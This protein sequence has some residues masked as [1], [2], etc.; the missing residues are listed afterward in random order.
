MEHTRSTIAGINAPRAPGRSAWRHIL[1]I[2]LIAAATTAHAAEIGDNARHNQSS[3]P[4]GAIPWL[5]GGIGD[6]ARDEMRKVQGEYNVLI[7]F[8]RRQGSY[9]ANI[10]F[11][12]SAAKEREILSGISEGPLLYLR[13]PAG[14]YR[15]SAKID[16]AWQSQNA[17]AG[18][19]ASPVRLMFVGHEE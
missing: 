1:A 16:G 19:P 14:S 15:V 7:V 8:S 17:R 3:S 9:M 11:A 13:L 6:E 12:V 10:P 5:S 2:A 18:T 4:Q